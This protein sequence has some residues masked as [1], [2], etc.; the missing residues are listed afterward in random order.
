MNLPDKQAQAEAAL[1]V[2]Q[3]KAKVV[4]VPT[5]PRHLEDPAFGDKTPAVV[6]WYRD[7]D[8]EE[9]KRRYAGRKT[10]LEDRRTER[11]R[12]VAP[13]T[14]HS[15]H[16]QLRT[17]QEQVT[18]S[19]NFLDTAGVETSSDMPCNGVSTPIPDF[20]ASESSLLP[21]SEVPLAYQGASN[22]AAERSERNAGITRAET[23]KFWAR[24]RRSTRTS[25]RLTRQ[26]LA[27]LQ[28]TTSAGK[29]RRRYE[30]SENAKKAVDRFSRSLQSR[31]KLV[32]SPFPPQN[33]TWKQTF[34]T[35][36]RKPNSYP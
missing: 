8:P 25:R 19:L 9:Y 24:L 12:T 34:W 21:Q 35:G 26:R 3:P 2:A 33:Q 18:T 20:G 14:G 7:N 11:R 22:K 6:E 29:S 30:Q 36:T 32:E 15:A 5:H 28:T 1:G 13:D 23:I 31:S 10:H 27:A 17:S 16:D 4:P